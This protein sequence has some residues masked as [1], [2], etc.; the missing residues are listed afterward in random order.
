[1]KRTVEVSIMGQK[2]MVRSDSDEH[3]VEKIAEYVNTK[4]AEIT[5]KSKSIPSLNVVILAAMNI[6]DDYMRM[7]HEKEKVYAGVE[8]KV[9]GMLEL[10]DLQL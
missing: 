10:I 7:R 4:V 8:K 1:M 9:L 2:F 6:A 3:Y 5:T